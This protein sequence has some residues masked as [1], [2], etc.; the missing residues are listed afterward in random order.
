MK[1]I[2][3]GTR[4]S[5]LARAQSRQFGENL[6]KLHPG[7]EVELVIITTS[8]DRFSAA[9]N[10]GKKEVPPGVV[11]APNVKAMFVKEIETALLDGSIDAAVHSA[12]DLPAELPDGLQI[13]AYP[14]RAD[15]RDAFIGGGTLRRFDDLPKGALVGTASLRRSIQ[16]AVRRPDLRFAPLRGNID[17]RLRKLSEGKASCVILAEAGLVRLGRGEVRRE[18]LGPEVLISAPGQGALAVEARSDRS[19][20]LELLAAIDHPA[21]RVEVELERGFMKE[22]GGGCATP[23]GALAR[24]GDSEVEMTVFWS[25]AQ[26]AH[27]V[28]LEGRAARRPEALAKL[29]ADMS[30]RIK[31]A[32]LKKRN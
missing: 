27:P 1:R 25:D 31:E 3:I 10:A 8:G 22:I 15:P 30:A 11:D 17:T 20:V 4:G 23:L 32:A 26:G 6:K 7:L 12:K 9:I 5:A 13:A 2:K 21:T 19:D 29:V 14:L 24:A 18:T 16:L 28:R